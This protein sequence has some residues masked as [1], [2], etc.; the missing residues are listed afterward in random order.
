MLAGDITIASCTLLS[1][2]E[3]QWHHPWHCPSRSQLSPLW[4]APLRF[5]GVGGAPGGC[6]T[7]ECRIKPGRAALGGRWEFGV[8]RA[9]NPSGPSSG[10]A[11]T[12][13]PCAATKCHR[14]MPSPIPAPGGKWRSCGQH[15]PFTGSTEG[16]QVDQA[17]EQGQ[18]SASWQELG[19]CCPLTASCSHEGAASNTT[20]G[21]SSGEREHELGFS[22]ELLCSP[23]HEMVLYDPQG[24]RDPCSTVPEQGVSLGAPDGDI[25]PGVPFSGQP[26]GHQNT[27]S[28]QAQCGHLAVG[29]L[30]PLGKTSYFGSF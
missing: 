3:H 29:A 16:A 24:L 6:D 1:C 21:P 10:W 23:W 4:A 13:S 11:H 20:A 7:Q 9:A 27:P 19:P 28:A 22:Q 17:T 12:E 2:A 18:G 15:V 25:S 30:P 14:G 26:Q 8:S 5:L